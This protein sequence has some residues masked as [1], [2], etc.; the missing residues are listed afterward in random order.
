MS[1]AGV[2]RVLAWGPR[3]ERVR[4]IEADASTANVEFIDSGEVATVALSDCR[5]VAVWSDTRSAAGEG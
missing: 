3:D 5:E 1:A 4:V 2:G